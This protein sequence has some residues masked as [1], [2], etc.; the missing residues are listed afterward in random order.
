MPTPR[1]N[2][3]VLD[4]ELEQ[5]QKLGSFGFINNLS[6]HPC[7]KDTWY[8]YILLINNTLSFVKFYCSFKSFLL[9]CFIIDAISVVGLTVYL[10]DLQWERVYFIKNVCV[11]SLCL[12]ILI[13]KKHV[14]LF[15]KS[16]CVCVCVFI[17]FHIHIHLHIYRSSFTR[18]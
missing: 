2:P 3:N 15:L 4:D 1:K 9:S 5:I 18:L 16:V 13:I 14:Y 12:N 10:L 8:I 17:I 7:F 11:F 6:L